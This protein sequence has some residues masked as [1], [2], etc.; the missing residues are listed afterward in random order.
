MS[1]PGIRMHQPESRSQCTGNNL[2]LFGCQTNETWV[3]GSAG[4]LSQQ[5][6]NKRDR[7]RPFTDR[8]R[9]AFDIACTNISRGKNTGQ[10]GFQQVG[11]ATEGPVRAAQLF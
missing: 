4:L 7:G 6:V 3:E 10:A 5:L 9:N 11:P 2:L 1:L 8:R